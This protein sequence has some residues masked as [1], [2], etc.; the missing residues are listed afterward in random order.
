MCKFS[1]SAESEPIAA[2]GLRTLKRTLQDS[3]DYEDSFESQQTKQQRIQVCSRDRMPT[4][5]GSEFSVSS[6]IPISHSKNTY[7]N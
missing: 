5:F 7:L 4:A 3:I 1:C 2:T 6:D